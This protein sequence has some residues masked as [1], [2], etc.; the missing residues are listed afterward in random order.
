MCSSGLSH[1]SLPGQAGLLHFPVS[2]RLDWD[3]VTHSGR[4][5]M[6]R[7]DERPPRLK[8]GRAGVNFL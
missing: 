8:R 3:H 4:W 7:S 2:L 6:S 1:L 5:A